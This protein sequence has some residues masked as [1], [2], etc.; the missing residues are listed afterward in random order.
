[1]ATFKLKAYDTRAVLEVALLNPDG[2]PHDLTGSTGWQLRVL[3]DDGGIFVRDLVKY[4]LDTDGT[5]RYDWTA[6]DWVSDV[7]PPAVTLPIPAY[8][9]ARRLLPMEYVVLGGAVGRMTFPNEGFDWLDITR[10]AV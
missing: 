7:S 4:G 6:A 5:L 3:R 9:G 1:M 10:G 2:T 8:P